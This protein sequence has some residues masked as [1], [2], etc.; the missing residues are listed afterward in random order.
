[1]FICDQ[2]ITADADAAQIWA[3]MP[4]LDRRVK[5]KEVITGIGGRN[6]CRGRRARLP[7][8]Q[9]LVA[10]LSSETAP[11]RQSLWAGPLLF[12]ADV[13]EQSFERQCWLGPVQTALRFKERDGA[14]EVATVCGLTVLRCGAGAEPSAPGL[15]QPRGW[16][17]DLRLWHLL[18]AMSTAPRQNP[19]DSRGAG[20][21]LSA[22]DVAA[23]CVCSSFIYDI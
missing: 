1:M 3:E 16:Q 17:L 15:P 23:L 2:R 18:R 4:R 22:R 5:G 19:A 7:R 14:E 10:G 9:W 6:S 12:L 13:Y 11:C 20:Y 21:P 8:L